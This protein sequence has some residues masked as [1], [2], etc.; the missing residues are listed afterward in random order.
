MPAVPMI[1]R[2]KDPGDGAEQAAAGQAGRDEARLGVMKPG[3]A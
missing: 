2:H 3:W 1:G